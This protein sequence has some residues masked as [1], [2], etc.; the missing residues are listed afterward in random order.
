MKNKR[1]MSYLGRVIYMNE[2]GFMVAKGD[3]TDEYFVSIEEAMN[4][5]EIGCYLNKD[6]TFG[7]VNTMK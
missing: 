6:K 2:Y 5:I 3:G 7:N 4:Y 1:V